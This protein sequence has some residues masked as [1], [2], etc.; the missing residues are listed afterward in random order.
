MAKIVDID[1]KVIVNSMKKV[2][3]EEIHEIEDNLEK[4]YAKYSINNSD[5][6]ESKLEDDMNNSAKEDLEKIKELEKELEKLYSYLR[7]VN[8]KSI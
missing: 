8:L 3:I 6:L 1:D 5:E 4:L 2:F 7:E